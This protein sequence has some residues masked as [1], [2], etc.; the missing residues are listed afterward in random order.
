[1]R[2]TLYE[3]DKQVSKVIISFHSSASSVPVPVFIDISYCHSFLILFTL[4]SV[5][6]YIIVALVCIL[7]VTNDIEHILMCLFY[8]FMFLGLC[9]SSFFS[10][11]V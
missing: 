7:L 6:L 8:V 11:S 10:V 3:N 5:K 1:M 4:V 2:L 9:T